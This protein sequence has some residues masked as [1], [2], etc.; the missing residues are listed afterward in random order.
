MTYEAYCSRVG[1]A[2]K[3]CVLRLNM[4]IWDTLP[5]WGSGLY[6]AGYREVDRELQDLLRMVKDVGK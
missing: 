3:D 5:R 1:E 4:G 6:P 2:V